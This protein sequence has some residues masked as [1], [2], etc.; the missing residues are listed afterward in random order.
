MSTLTRHPSLE[1]GTPNDATR[2]LKIHSSPAQTSRSH[3]CHGITPDSQ[4]PRHTAG[5]SVRL[6]APFCADHPGVESP[7]LALHAV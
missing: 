4:R 2:T 3:H 5:P 1:S 7:Y 6:L